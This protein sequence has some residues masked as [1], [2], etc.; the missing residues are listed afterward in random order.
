VTTEPNFSVVSGVLEIG[1][2]GSLTV[3]GNYT[4]TGGI[5]QSDVASSSSYGQLTVVGQATLGGILRLNFLS[6]AQLGDYRVLTYGSRVG[7]FGGYD[8]IPSLSGSG[9][10]L[11]LSDDQT[12]LSV[13]PD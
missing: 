2:T 12:T 9:M 11:M 6:P 4:Q 8:S 5:L 13:V 3:G 7:T 10:H 1:A